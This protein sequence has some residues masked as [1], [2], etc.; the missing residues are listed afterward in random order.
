M[1]KPSA[2]INACYPLASRW[3]V[4]HGPLPEVLLSNIATDIEVVT[5]ELGLRDEMR[6][7]L[8]RALTG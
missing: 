5:R 6:E 1:D 7:R 4:P 3:T 2:D 8:R